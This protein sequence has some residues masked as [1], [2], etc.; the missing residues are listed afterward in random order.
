[1]AI[2]QKDRVLSHLEIKGSINPL[3][4]WSYLGVYRLS[5]VIFEL[6]KLGHKIHTNYID[7]ENQFG[8]KCNVAEYVLEGRGNGK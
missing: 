8:E 1:M 3:I 6:R 2:T 5:A 7:V 4:S